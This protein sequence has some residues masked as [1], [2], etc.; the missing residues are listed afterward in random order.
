[1][2]IIPARIG[3]SRFP[4]KVLADILGVPMVIRTAQAVAPLDAVT[5][6][7]DSVEVLELAEEY[8]IRAVM[9]STEHQSGTDRIFEAAT[10][11][12]LP[13]DEII[14][15]VQADEPFIEEE[16]VEKVYQLTRQN[17]SD[18]S[19]LAC[20]AY[21]IVSNPEAD[22][23][24]LVKVVTDD[25][26]IALYFSRAKIPYPRD[27]HF[28]TYKGHLGLY[29]Y[30]MA[31]LKTFCE[32]EPAKLEEVEKLEQLR[33]LAHGYRVAMVKVETESFGI[34]MP[35]DLQKVMKKHLL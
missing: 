3:S 12:E 17:A 27:H 22:D 15:N 1:M 6:A 26:D 18:P 13:D 20:S 9:T 7:T 25:H 16:V 33:I 35:E 4:S 29:G 24:N 2:I 30:T 10:I 23:P 32:L 19:I 11:L 14:I 28:D 21:K 34:D 8:G 5:I 31:S